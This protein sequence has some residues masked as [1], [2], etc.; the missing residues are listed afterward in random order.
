MGFFED[1]SGFG[2]ST[3]FHDN[4]TVLTALRQGEEEAMEALRGLT[5]PLSLQQAAPCLEKAL[6]AGPDP[7]E[8]GGGFSCFTLQP[9]LFEEIKVPV[10][11]Q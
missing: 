3:L 1:T 2:L 8:E 6:D 10:T 5:Q 4:D 11:P 9:C 7:D